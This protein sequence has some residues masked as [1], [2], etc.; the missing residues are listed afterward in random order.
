MINV[1]V[2]F[3]R[4]GFFLNIDVDNQKQFVSVRRYISTVF[5]LEVDMKSV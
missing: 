4:S 5:Q 3:R 1:Y 2:S